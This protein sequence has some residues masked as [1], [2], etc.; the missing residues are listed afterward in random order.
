MA[1]SVDQVKA[2]LAEVP[3]PEI[4][5]LSL[6]DLGVIRNV[7]EEDGRVVVTITPTYSG[8]PATSVIALDIET[9][10]RRHGVK[11]LEIRR[12]LSPAWT[13][14]W[15][16]EAG[17]RNLATYGIAPPKAD[18]EACAGLLAQQDVRCPRCGSAKTEMVS[19]RGSTPC[20]ALFRCGSCREPFDYLKAI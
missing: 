16:S 6:M 11:N 18:A 5:V 14:D 7:D 2:W 15:I 12:Q 10:L 20:K 3:D 4:P 19:G 9:A 1:D 8:C 17:R 13:T